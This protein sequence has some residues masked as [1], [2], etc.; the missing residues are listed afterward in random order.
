VALALDSLAGL[1][2]HVV[3]ALMGGNAARLY[4]VAG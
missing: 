1:D 2:E 4:D 3:A